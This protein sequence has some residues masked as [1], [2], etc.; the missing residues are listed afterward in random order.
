MLCQRDTT[1]RT[2]RASPCPVLL[3]WRIRV[4]WAANTTARHCE[5]RDHRPAARHRC[6]RGLAAA[7]FA[8][9]LAPLHADAACRREPA[10]ADRARTRSMAGRSRRPPLLRRHQQLVGEPVRSF[11]SSHQRRAEGPDR[12]PPPRD[13][14]GL[15]ARPSRATRRAPVGADGRRPRP[16][17]LR[18]RRRVGR[19]DRAEDELSPLAQRGASCK[20]GVRVPAPGLSR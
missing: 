10:A 6:Q 15:H 14:G 13:A 19:G 20:A 18:Q 17:L 12:P 1:L 7:H 9:C 4:R 2:M 3:R 5:R 8:P 11:G 16:L